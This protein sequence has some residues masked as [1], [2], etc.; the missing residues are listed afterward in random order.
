[1]VEASFK[2]N[3]LFWC[4]VQIDPVHEDVTGSLSTLSLLFITSYMTSVVRYPYLYYVGIELRT[5]ALPALLIYS[6]TPTSTWNYCCIDFH[7][8]P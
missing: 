1:M 4:P 7:H 6:H 2:P 8:V 3:Q 5:P